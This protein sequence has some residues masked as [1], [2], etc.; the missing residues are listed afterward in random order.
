[1]RRLE[2]L[3]R[4]AGSASLLV[5]IV[6]CQSVLAHNDERPGADRRHKGRRVIHHYELVERS[7]FVPRTAVPTPVPDW[8]RSDWARD[9][10]PAGG[11]PPNLNEGSERGD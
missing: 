10:L 6:L 4:R 5:I 11:D 1:M 2:T 7:R 8:K 9:V 3:L